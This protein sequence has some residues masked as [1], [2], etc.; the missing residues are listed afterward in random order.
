MNIKDLYNKILGNSPD[1]TYRSKLYM[2]EGE[3][4]KELSKYK[5]QIAKGKGSCGVILISERE[6]DLFDIV[7]P[8]QL[9]MT[10][11]VDKHPV[12]AGIAPDKDE[13]AELVRKII[14][15]CAKKRGDLNI[16]EYI[17]SL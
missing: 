4:A 2:I 15:D 13:A 3:G 14:E 9:K 1:L 12:V 5:K 8:F 10:V 16:K 6:D 11:W 7:T 17:C